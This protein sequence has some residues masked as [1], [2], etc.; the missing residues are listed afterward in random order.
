M[1][2]ERYRDALS[3]LAA[4]GPAQAEVELHLQSCEACRVELAQ[5]RQVLGIVDQELARLVA[6]EPSP[7]LAARIRSVVAESGASPGW[8]FGWLW[9]AAGVGV[10]VLVALALVT[11]RDRSPRAEPSLASHATTE[12]SRS[13]TT[14]SE[15]ALGSG[16]AGAASAHAATPAPVRDRKEPRSTPPT[17]STRLIEAEILVPPGQEE[18]LL[19]FADDLQRRQVRLGSLLVADVE[20]PLP[21]PGDIDL[22]LLETKPLDT[23]PLDQS[24]PS[25][26]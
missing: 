19:R 13:R 6:A 2:C 18:A 17:A 26:T 8:G 5:L 22:S 4:G 1:A 7:E 21:E 3:D 20:A 24:S 12:A 23:A 10:A 16:R 14:D 11:S 15:V 25:D 9:P